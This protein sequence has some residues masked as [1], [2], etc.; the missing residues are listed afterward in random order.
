MSP[1]DED[2]ARRK[3]T[4]ISRCLS[5]LAKSSGTS[6]EQYLADADLQSIVERQLELAIGAAID[7]NV[8]LL[9][10][11]GHG[12]PA[13]AFTSFLDLARHTA[14]IPEEL[15]RQLAPASGLRNRL[16]HDY[17]EIDQEM[18][19]RGVGSALELLP[20]YVS[21]I[22]AYLGDVRGQRV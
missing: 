10:G 6:L 11:G 13:D 18:V 14:A 22:E 9:V 17:E 20:R 3:L 12:T 16:A 8:H 7:L 5:R 1:V 19:Y 4:R 15:A 2:V 21:A